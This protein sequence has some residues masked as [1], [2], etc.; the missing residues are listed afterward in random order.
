[1]L[2]AVPAILQQH[3]PVWLVHYTLASLSRFLVLVVLLELAKVHI[4][5]R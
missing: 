5:S 2:L 1:L 4:C 3:S